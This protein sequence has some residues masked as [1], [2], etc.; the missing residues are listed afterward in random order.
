MRLETHW[1]NGDRTPRGRRD[2][3]IRSDGQM[4]EVEAVAGG[5]NGRS[6]VH[7][8]PGRQSAEILAGAWMGGPGRW[9]K[10]AT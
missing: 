4:W 1:W 8:C 10:V 6:R 5:N 2:V 9:R 3:F 7:R